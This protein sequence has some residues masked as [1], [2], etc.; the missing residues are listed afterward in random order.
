MKQ[1][2]FYYFIIS[3]IVKL[4]GIGTVQFNDPLKYFQPFLK[5]LISICAWSSFLICQWPAPLALWADTEQPIGSK[6]GG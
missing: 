2:I 1:Q 4:V 5:D 3:L 6:A